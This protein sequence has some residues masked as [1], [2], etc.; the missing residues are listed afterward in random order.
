MNRRV[1][2][3]YLLIAAFGVAAA[4]TVVA[5]TDVTF[6]MKNGQRMSGAF[7]YHHDANYNLIIN[8]QERV[9][10]SDDI[11]LIEFVPGDPPAGEIAALSTDGNPPEHDRHMLAFR[12]GRTLRGKI[13]DFQ[14]DRILID[15][16]D[17]SGQ[18]TRQ[19]YSM[20]EVARLYV[21]AP[22][23]RD[24]FPDTGRDRFQGRGRGRA[25]GQQDL[26]QPTNVSG[27]TV[28]VDA[29]SAW[30][31]TGIDVRRGDQ[32]SFSTTGEIMIDPRI[33]TGADGTQSVGTPDIPVR[34]LGVGGLIGRV[35]KSEAFAIGANT[36]SITMPA[37]GRLFLGVNDNR[38]NDNSGFF[39]V[40]IRR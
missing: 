19:T 2:P 11:A 27:P 26:P 17:G 31:D 5:A 32:V 4:A 39:N 13:Y 8:G 36:Q 16:R 33:R 22:A 38:F 9:I 12:D 25:R 1:R 3:I 14:G 21:S 29:R 37:S 30:T 34:T 28:R 24:L 10:P 40:T 18:I 35:G 20:G 6:V 23:S 7:V 15:A